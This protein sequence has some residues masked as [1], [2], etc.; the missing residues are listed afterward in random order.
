MFIYF[1]FVFKTR[2]KFLTGSIFHSGLGLLL[3]LITLRKRLR[4]KLGLL[5]LGKILKLILL[6]MI[7]AKLGRSG[8]F[9]HASWIILV[10]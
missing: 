5:A 8:T 9:L 10:L 4:R 2:V 7:N 3:K 1:N 6:K